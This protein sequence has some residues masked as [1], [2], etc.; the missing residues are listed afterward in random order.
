MSN[1][2]VPRVPAMSWAQ[3]EDEANRLRRRVSPE[4]LKSIQRLNLEELF[5]FE[6]KQLYGYDYRVTKDY[7]YKAWPFGKAKKRR[8]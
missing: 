4:S 3:I 2:Q 8:K 1:D 5:E 7:G 6:L